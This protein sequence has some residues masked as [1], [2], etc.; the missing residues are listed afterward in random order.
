MHL[1]HSRAISL[2]TE[3][4]VKIVGLG[5]VVGLIAPLILARFVESLLYGVSTTDPLRSAPQ[6]LCWCWPHCWRVCSRLSAPRES[7]RSG[8]CANKK[9]RNE[10]NE[11]S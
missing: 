10:L 11:A 8:R 7:I 9:A 2:I 5:F 1:E 3:Q 4:G 6:Y